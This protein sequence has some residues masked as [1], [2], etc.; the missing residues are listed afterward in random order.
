MLGAGEAR[1]RTRL[2][3]ERTVPSGML[4]HTLIVLWYARHGYDRAGIDARRNDQPWYG[5]K[6]EPAFEDMLIKL[7]RTLIATRFSAAGPGQPTNDEIRSVTSAWAA[8][9]A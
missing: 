5:D 2:A 8:A 7:R 3:V 6:T 4:A 1:N 9:A